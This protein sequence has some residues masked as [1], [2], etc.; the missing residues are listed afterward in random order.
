[1]YQYFQNTLC[2]EAGQL[3]NC[4]VI[5]LSHYKQL[6]YRGYLNVIRRGGNGRTALIEFS[7]MREDIK[8]K[9]E[10]LYPKEQ[11]S[12]TILESYLV[13][14]Q[15]AAHYFSTFRKANGKP[16]S[17]EKQKEYTT[18]AI[19]L[20]AIDTIILEK[21]TGRR[22]VLT[23]TTKLWE[24]ISNLVNQL[25]SQKFNHSIPGNYR[26]LERLYKR[27]KESSYSCLVH[28][29]IDNDNRRKIDGDIAD[30]IL[31]TYCLPNKPLIPTVLSLYDNERLAKG[32]PTLSE[33]AIGMFLDQPEVKRVWTLARHGKETFSNMF[34]H[35][36]SRD[37]SEWF[38]NSYWA[39]DGTKLD[40]V[41][42]QDNV[43]G[44]AAKLKI[45]PV[46]DVF[47]EMI[48][49]YSLSE[50]E[51]HVDHF[52]AL[53][54]AINF[55]QAKPYK[56]TYDNQSGHKSSRMQE[57]YDGIIAKNGVHNPTA[58]RMK[59]NPAEQIFNRLQQQVISTF[60]FSDKQSVK[61]RD[62]DNVPN[63]DFILENKH[64]LLSKEDLIK[65]WE[66]AVKTWNNSTHPLISNKT[67]AE[68]YA[69]PVP[70]S[71]P[72]D[73]LDMIN[74]F[75]VNE[76]KAITYKNDGLHLRIAGKEYIFEVYD[77]N[78]KIDLNFRR[79]N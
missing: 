19:I 14:D 66:L 34:G 32:W 35:R 28:G 31:A 76:T 38:A 25:P 8:R 62:K 61:S 20:N 4:G 64:R 29:G 2:V 79:Y 39:I 63:I 37:R 43:T 51:N 50:T 7:S 42:Y 54:S 16:L 48:I 52:T 36:L 78:D 22:K 55:S 9:I 45:N 67:R 27:F 33:Q 53:K 77:Q 6:V 58:P 10:E 68:V 40:W 41:H 47:S 12:Q 26:S 73:F 59:S 13:P 24:T 70:M 57:L 49:G 60:W 75:W 17:F 21:K 71:E 46:F 5:T 44:L 30:F 1:M 74:L 11:A 72:V 3:V 56:L 23:K 18:N 15:T 69:M 65:A